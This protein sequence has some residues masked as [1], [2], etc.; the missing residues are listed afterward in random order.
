MTP[1]NAPFESLELG[2]Y[3]KYSNIRKK[4]KFMGHSSTVPNFTK[5]INRKRSYYF[6]DVVM[7][8]QVTW[9]EILDAV[10]SFNHFHYSRDKCF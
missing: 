10:Y 1:V 9:T 8:F 5:K 6:L 2:F 7:C 3:K 4:W